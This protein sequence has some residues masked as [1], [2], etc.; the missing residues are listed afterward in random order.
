MRDININSSTKSKG[1]WGRCIILKEGSNDKKNNNLAI[2][3]GF[4]MQEWE[5][6]E[7]ISLHAVVQLGKPNIS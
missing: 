5:N 3:R 1:L 2:Q 6:P 7:D 4:L